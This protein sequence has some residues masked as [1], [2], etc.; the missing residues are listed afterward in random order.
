MSAVAR[1]ADKCSGHGCFPSRPNIGASGNV[2]VNGKGVQRL[3][4][5]YASHCCPIMVVTMVLFQLELDTYLLMEDLWLESETRYLVEVLLKKVLVTF[6][7]INIKKRKRIFSF[8]L[9]F[10]RLALSFC[11]FNL[12][13]NFLHSSNLFLIFNI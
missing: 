6:F 10:Y 3:G 8:F 7:V 2:F 4:D 11:K 5:P 12:V 9:N 1:F 13:V